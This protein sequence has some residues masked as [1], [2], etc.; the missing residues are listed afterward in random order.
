[1]C[2]SHCSIAV[3]RNHD[4]GNLYK[5]AVSKGEFMA[6]TLESTVK[7]DLEPEQQL[8][9][10][11]LISAAGRKRSGLLWAFESTKSPV[12]HLLLRGHTAQ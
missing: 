3:K 8:R 12:T 10:T 11:I 4:Q 9:A 2:L 7:A 5:N 1:M 6:I